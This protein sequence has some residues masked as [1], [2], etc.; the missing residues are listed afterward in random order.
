MGVWRLGQAGMGRTDSEAAFQ[1]F[2][3]RIPSATNLA[4]SQLES[5][6]LQQPPSASSGPS[7]LP[8]SSLEMGNGGSMLPLMHRVPSLDF[9]RQLVVNNQQHYA[10]PAAPS[11]VQQQPFIKSESPAPPGLL[12]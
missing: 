9:L 6:Q 11:V 12:V 3:K 8:T 2:L 1:E 4:A 10:P 5:S 7:G